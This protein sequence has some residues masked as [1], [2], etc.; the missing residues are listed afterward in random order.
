MRETRGEKNN[1]PSNVRATATHWQGE[2]A[3]STDSAFEQFDTVEQGIRAGAIVFLT[4][5]RKH[6]LETVRELIHRWAPPVENDTD[7][8]VNAVANEMGVGANDPLSLCDQGTMTKFLK[9][10]IRHENGRVIYA[11]S[12]IEDGVRRALA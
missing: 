10:V 1:N 12:V 8:Y 11:D 3:S 6:G 9:A 7:S 5:Q 4:Y 2:R